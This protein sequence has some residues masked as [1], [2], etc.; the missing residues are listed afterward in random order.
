MDILSFEIVDSLDKYEKEKNDLLKERYFVIYRLKVEQSVGLQ[1]EKVELNKQINMLLQP[2]GKYLF[3]EL[4]VVSYVML[5]L[6]DFIPLF[7]FI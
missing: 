4:C 3:F 6:T 7:R 2:I 5:R 1:N